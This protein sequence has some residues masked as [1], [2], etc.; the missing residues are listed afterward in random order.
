MQISSRAI[1]DTYGHVAG[2][3]VPSQ[4]AKRLDEI[5]QFTG[6]CFR[7]AGDEF[8]ILYPTSSLTKAELLK[9]DIQ[10]KIETFTLSELR[11]THLSI[12]VGLAAWQE[13]MNDEKLLR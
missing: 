4:I 9:E 11:S 13:G 8:T 2:D 3:A 1:N 7:Y 6:K 5:T 10:A 12:R